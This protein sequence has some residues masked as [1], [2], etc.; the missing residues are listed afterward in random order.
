MRGRSGQGGVTLVELV[1]ALMIG[2]GVVLG[3]G[4]AFALNTGLYL[5]N[6][7][8]L[9]VQSDASRA[10]EVIANAAGHA[11]AYSIPEEG[12]LRLAFPVSPLGQAEPLETIFRLEDHIL[13][14]DGE[15]LVPFRGDTTVGVSQFLAEESAM[16][17]NG[18]AVLTVKLKLYS[19]TGQD[20][21][22][23]TLAF[24]TTVHA[25]N[26]GMKMGK[27]Q[28]AAAPTQGDYL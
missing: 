9:T 4:Y 21:I 5:E 20:R 13:L 25:R 14:K 3:L 28:S 7:A 8:R 17:A 23:D 6:R 12:E 16:D 22:P 24:E 19:R 1:V 11:G 18:V 10:L 15:P 2:G 27:S 26:R